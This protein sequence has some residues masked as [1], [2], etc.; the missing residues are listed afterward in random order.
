[1]QF[2]RQLIECVPN[3]SEG[4]RSEVIDDIVSAFRNS[5]DVFL[6]DWRADADH[7]R[8]VV[9]LAG[10]PDAL[11][12]ALIESAK[13]AVNHI[14]MATHTGSHPRIGSVDVIPFTPLR[15]I[16]MEECVTFARDFGKRYFQET[17]IPVYFYE[18]A[19]LIPARR[20][21]ENVRRGQYECLCTDARTDPARCPDVGGSCLHDTA[22]AT[23]IGARKLLIAFNINLDTGDLNIAKR[24]A[25]AVRASS[26]GFAYV[27]GMAV[28]LSERGI[29]Q[30]SMNVVD[31]EKNPLYRILETVR[32]E[33]RR[34]GVDVLE[35][36]L[37]G[38][39]PARALTDSAEYY[40]RAAAFDPSQVIELKLLE[41]MEG[42][43][44]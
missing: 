16:T 35:T 29:T 30:V 38:M 20:K 37:Y 17:G 7:N 31:F 6:L 22:G 23:A 8:L 2:P 43:E 32:M 9:S 19:A 26:G 25:A 24:I 1:M 41:L 3:Y 5:R 44:K 13:T 18:D 14:D 27:K 34:W 4:R 36:E 33:A 12:E 11:A 10:P 15:G 42:D 39:I 40:L 28:E 21:L